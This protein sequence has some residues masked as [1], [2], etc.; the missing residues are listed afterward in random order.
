MAV[1]QLF[2]QI[3]V[4]ARKL[5]RQLESI[6]DKLIKTQSAIAFNNACVLNNI[7]PNYTHIRQ[8]DPARNNPE[9][10]NEFQMNLLRDEIKQKESRL[11]ELEYNRQETLT[12]AIIFYFYFYFYFRS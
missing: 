3:P 2:T 7:M 4:E 10:V 5:F 9:L 12:N 6:E 11:I 1:Q 8:R